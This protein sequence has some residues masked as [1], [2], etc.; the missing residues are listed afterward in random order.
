MSGA[1]QAVIAARR[2]A[3][4][5]DAFPLTQY[6][7][8]L[9]QLTQGDLGVSL[10]SGER[11]TDALLRNLSPTVAL[12]LS[13]GT[14]AGV[15]GIALGIV[16]ASGC[17]HLSA[18]TRALTALSLSVPIYW[19]GIVAIFLFSV[20]LSWLPASGTGSVA[21]YVLPASLVAFHTA[22]SIARVTHASVS[23]AAQADFVRTARA[24]GLRQTQ[25]VFRHVL[26][27]GLLPVVSAAA[28]QFGF[29]FSSAVVT[30]SMFV[31]PGIG[32]LLLDAVIKQDYPVVQGVV[33]VSALA[34]TLVI[35][36]A[37]MLNAHLDPRVSL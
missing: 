23:T 36:I 24:K 25:I 20:Q 18:I 31:R 34:Y 8:Y 6:M 14:A 33:L 2:A 3:L 21:H 11:V 27:V 32:R 30:E 16:S 9:Q 17:G 10:V 15:L 4:G 28:L 26:R 12:A 13:G 22:G 19:S 35:E 1:S 29:L 7:R 37:D 5:L